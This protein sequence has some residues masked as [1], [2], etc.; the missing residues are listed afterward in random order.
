MIAILY[1][2]VSAFVFFIS[3][4][5]WVYFFSLSFVAGARGCLEVGQGNIGVLQG[6]EQEPNCQVP[7][8]PLLM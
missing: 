5:D 2:D 6:R 3:Q 4:P 1:L 7:V 8:Q